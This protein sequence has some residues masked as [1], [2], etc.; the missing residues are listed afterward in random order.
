MIPTALSRT[1]QIIS[2]VHLEFIKRARNTPVF[3]PV[4]E[5]GYLALCGDIGYPFNPMYAE[6]IRQHSLLYKHIFVLSGN[7]EYYS[8]KN[9]QRSIS[10]VDSQIDQ[11]CSMFPNVTFLQKKEVVIEGTRFLGCTLWSD[12]SLSDSLRMNDYNCIYTECNVS[13]GMTTIPFSVNMNR[14]TNFGTS[15]GKRV[16]QKSG[17]RLITECDTRQLHNDMRT[18]LKNKLED[19]TQKTIVLTHHAPTHKLDRDIPS[20]GYST[21]LEYLMSSGVSHWLSGHTH[22]SKQTVINETTCISNCVG[23]PNEGC[24]F[25]PFFYIEF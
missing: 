17:K 10:D 8:G 12:I 20:T 24:Q 23:Y 6:F 18:W 22:L 19:K 9:K 15:L 25:N 7:H 3:H 13:G 14:T 11:V 16:W 2:D 4:S 5:N 21:N 1:L